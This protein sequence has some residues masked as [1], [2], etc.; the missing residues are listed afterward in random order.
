MLGTFH[1]CAHFM[2]PNR[3]FLFEKTQRI[4]STT[5]IIIVV[6]VILIIIIVTPQK[7]RFLYL[8]VRFSDQKRG[9]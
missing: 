3:S 5:I 7:L 2:L 1:V 9:F 8:T 4:C 6:V